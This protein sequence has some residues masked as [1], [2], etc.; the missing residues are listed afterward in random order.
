MQG[1]DQPQ[2][3]GRRWGLLQ[4]LP[5]SAWVP[6][7]KEQSGTG[8]GGRAWLGGASSRVPPAPPCTAAGTH[9]SPSELSPTPPQ[10]VGGERGPEERT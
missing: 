8:H 9:R 10:R 5:K 4:L 6:V 2:L 7:V 1:L 3:P